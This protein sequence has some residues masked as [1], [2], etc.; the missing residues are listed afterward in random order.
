M[1]CP[2]RF[3][4]A[5]VPA[6]CSLALWFGTR[7]GRHGW[8]DGYLYA[9][10]FLLHS[11]SLSLKDIPGSLISNFVLYQHMYVQMLYITN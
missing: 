2:F 4:T 6:A 1:Q 9:F 8:M 5:F 11:D 10:R 3:H 7:T